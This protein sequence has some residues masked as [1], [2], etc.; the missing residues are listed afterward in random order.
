MNP[1]LLL[2]L[3]LALLI[4]L[5]GV[6]LVLYQRHVFRSQR[7]QVEEILREMRELTDGDAEPPGERDT[8]PLQER[9]TE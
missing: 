1:L 6:G 9:G 4:F 8:E 7:E 2:F 5:G 3:G